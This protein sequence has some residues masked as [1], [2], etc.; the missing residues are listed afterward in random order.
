MDTL[1][2]ATHITKLYD[3]VPS[4]VNV[5]ITG[6][7]GSIHAV[8]GEN[9]AGKSTLMKIIAGVVTPNEGQ[10]FLRGKP[11]KFSSPLDA[12]NAGISTV[13]QE[14]S[15]VGN[16]T[17]AETMFLGREPKRGLRGLYGVDRRRMEEE[18]RVALG[19]IGLQID[20]RRLVSSLTV[21]E[22]QSVEI[23]KGLA[24]NADIFIFDEPTAALN[25]KD[26]ERIE[27]LLLKLR[28]GGKC[29]FYISHRMREIFDL[30]DTA[31]VLKDGKLVGSY[32]TADL[33]PDRLLSLMVGRDVEQLYPPRAEKR[34][35][36][37]LRISG[38]CTAPERPEV[39]FTVKRGEIVALGGLEGQG[40]RDIVRALAGVV[41]G[42]NGKLELHRRSGAQI[43]F[44]PR[45]GARRAL[46]NGL[47][48]MPEDRKGEGLYL[49]LP[50]RDNLTLGVHQRN[51]PW[52]FA[53]PLTALIKRLTDE[54]RIRAAS[55]A[56]AVVYLSG[57]N[58]QKVMLGRWIA[59]DADVLLIEEPTRGVDVGAKVEIY[60]ALRTFCERGGSV[61][62]TSR[63]LPEVIGLADR[64]LVVSEHRIV[65]EMDAKDASE[66]DI[67][68]A[69]VSRAGQSADETV[70][71]TVGATS[72]ASA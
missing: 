12:L 68:Q 8:T 59:I 32:P 2:A 61:L 38:L 20:P 36:V 15:L 54:L 60:T 49:D 41:K 11:V 26:V 65:K 56:Q 27:T 52:A 22:Q 19:Y 14:F 3:G 58:Q 43:T 28:D 10:V 30:C 64:I 69:A 4:L 44:R 17:V 66:E 67:L 39:D 18:A 51:L 62:F 40:Q 6:K 31:T 1:V 57:G 24:V 63:E 55:S 13:F 7:A 29:I 21:A 34:D 9:G 70:R 25:T 35:E 33:N 46:S 45:A 72:G 47:A 42:C 37:A 71:T 16:L 23:A 50:I 5:G 48:F 53:R